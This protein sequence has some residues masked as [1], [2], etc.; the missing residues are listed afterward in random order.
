LEGRQQMRQVASAP[1]TSGRKLV[2]PAGTA[3]QAAAAVSSR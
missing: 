3:Q 1:G 2:N